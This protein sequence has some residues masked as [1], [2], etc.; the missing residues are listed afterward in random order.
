MESI[1]VDSCVILDVFENDPVWYSWSVDILDHYSRT[2]RLCI[3]PVIYTEISIGFKKIEELE[4]VISDCGFLFLPVPKEALFLAGKAF[5]RYR[6]K[7]GTKKRP[8]PDFYIGAHAAVSGLGL[9]TRNVKR[10]RWYFPTVN[11]VSP[12]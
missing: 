11:I 7:K 2:H 5:I 4:E 8:L 12:T 10:V 9:I 3:N 6:R 1:L